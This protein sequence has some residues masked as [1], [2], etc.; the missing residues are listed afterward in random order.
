[1][2]LTCITTGVPRRDIILTRFAE[3]SGAKITRMEWDHE[4]IPVIVGNTHGNDVIQVECL[5]RK[6]PFLYW[7][8][9]YLTRGYE[10]NT[11]RLCLSHYHTTD[12]RESDNPVHVH[13]PWHQGETVIVI[14]PSD[15]VKRINRAESWLDTTIK[16]LSEHTDRRIIVKEKT[17]GKLSDLL[18]N[19]HAVVSFGSVAEVEAALSGVPVFTTCGPSIPIALQDFTKIETPIYPDRVKWLQ[20]LKG[21]EWHLDEMQKAWNHICPLLH[22]PH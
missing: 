16:T 18:P 12:W 8:H 9:G 5:E 14:P 19:A 10:T 20:A 7:D 22:T 2:A 3:A 21:A 15:Y 17:V 4:S 11:F 1:M 13:E 6:H